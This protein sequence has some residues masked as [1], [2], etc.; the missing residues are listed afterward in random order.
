MTPAICIFATKASFSYVYPNLVIFFLCLV[1]AVNAAFTLEGELPDGLRDTEL[2]I[3]RESLETRKLETLVSSY[4]AG[5]RLSETIDAEGGLFTLRLGGASAKFVAND[6]DTLELVATVEGKPSIQVG[7][8]EA[9]ENFLAY[10]AFRKASLERLVYPV[11][12]KIS[13]ARGKGNKALVE[14][15]T[16]AEV[17]AY[18]RHRDEL[19]DFVID[20]MGR[21]VAL[22]ATSLRWTGEHRLEEL[23]SA[24]EAFAE[25]YPKSEVAQLMEARIDRFRATALGAI[26][27]NLIGKSPEGEEVSLADYR[28]QIVLVDFWAAWCGPCRITN[29]QYVDLYSDFHDKGFEIVAVS[30]DQNESGW[31][32]AIRQDKATWVHMSDLVGWGSPLAEAYNVSALPMNFLLDREGRILATGVEGEE[33]AKILRRELP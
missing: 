23:A 6:G 10:E 25:T 27:P 12:A 32:R 8:S 7:G 33:L 2:T 19:N 11:R 24:V 16:K 14:S 17:E 18:A 3:A 9:Q 28:G 26:A 21:T 30:V 1:T 15:L 5:L 22:Y 29:R 4:P 13:A 31:K 20:Q